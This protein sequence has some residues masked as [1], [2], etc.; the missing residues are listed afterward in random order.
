GGRIA[1]L[2]FQFPPEKAMENPYDEPI[3]P[4][5]GVDS[6]RNIIIGEGEDDEHEFTI[7]IDH[8]NIPELGSRYTTDVGELRAA[9]DSQDAWESYLLLRDN[10]EY[11]INPKGENTANFKEGVKPFRNLIRGRIHG[12]RL[13]N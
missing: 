13:S 10:N 6:N 9:L 11:R 3:W 8:W 4:Y 12:D 5:W 1:K 2:F 7:E